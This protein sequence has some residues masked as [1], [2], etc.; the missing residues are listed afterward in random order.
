MHIYAN[1]Y[2]DFLYVCCMRLLIEKDDFHYLSYV[3]NYINYII[4]KC[5]IHIHILNISF[6]IYIS[7]Y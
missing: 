1:P 3:L 5:Q 7:C 6:P 2:T 4:V